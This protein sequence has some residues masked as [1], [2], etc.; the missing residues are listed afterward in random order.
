MRRITA[1]IMA[2]GAAVLLTS[3]LATTQEL[4]TD[5]TTY[6]TF[7]APVA[8]PGITLPAGDYM[9]RLLN[10]QVNR[11]VVQIYDH[12]RTKLFAT[13]M[14]MPAQRNEISGET[15]ITFR[16]APAN[17]APAIRY[18]YFPGDRAG[19]EFAYPK[20]QAIQIANASHTPVLAVDAAEGDPTGLK[21][22]EMTHVQPDAT[23][24][25]NADAGRT[26]RAD[27]SAQSSQTATAASTPS[28]DTS[29]QS[30]QTATAAPAAD[31]GRTTQQPQP[32]TTSDTSSASTTGQSSSSATA[33][34]T[35]G[36]STAGTSAQSGS[37]TPSTSSAQAGSG[38]AAS[39]PAQSGNGSAASAP[40]AERHLPN[41]GS[42]LPLVGL[43]G[44]LALLGAFG[45]RAVRES[46]V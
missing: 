13:V 41:T 38:N 25:Q 14:A 27:T 29:A 46:I 35:S 15:V 33:V 31:A 11:N 23:A 8:L 10:S 32:S 28:A 7:S 3:T 17:A 9:F 43:A 1:A 6:V 2:M 16:E 12:D 21:G 5:K 24:E 19:Q 4:N 39:A 36:R 20:S 34:G 40:S 18:W 26:P 22:G 45:V 30:S 37:A 44:L 42:E